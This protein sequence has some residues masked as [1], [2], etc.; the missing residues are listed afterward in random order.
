LFLR[1]CPPTK[2]LSRK[3][4]TVC[5][6]TVFE[7]K[8]EFSKINQ[9]SKSDWWPEMALGPGKIRPECCFNQPQ[10]IVEKI[11]ITFGLILVLR[12]K[13]IIKNG[14]NAKN[15]CKK[16]EIQNTIGGRK[17]HLAGQNSVRRSAKPVRIG[18]S[19]FMTSSQKFMK[20][21]PKNHP[22]QKTPFFSGKG[23]DLK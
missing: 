19:N 22:P 8:H 17:W 2:I 23:L 10:R 11:F 1:F 21:I 5:L 9:N 12:K 20:K 14:Q 7:K 16:N 4:K 6:L 15:F 3:T 18:M 13:N